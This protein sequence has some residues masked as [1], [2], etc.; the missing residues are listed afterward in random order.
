MRWKGDVGAPEHNPPPDRSRKRRR[1]WFA[2]ASVTLV[3]LLLFAGL[4]AGLRLFDYGYPATYFVRTESGDA[5]TGNR[6]F[7][8]R[9]FPRHFARTP[10]VFSFPSDKP[11]GTYRIFVMGGSAARGEPDEA[12]NF[13]RILGKMLSSHYPDARF[14]VINT[15]MVA[16]NSHVVHQIARECARLEPDLFIV[17][18]G[19]NEVIGPYG[20]GTVFR[21][22][23][24][25]LTTIR[26]GIRV[27][28]SRT[29]QLLDS[30]VQSVSGRQ[31]SVS[32]WRGMEMFLENRVRFDDPRLKSGYAHFERNL[33]DIIRAARE[34]GAGIILSTVATNLKDNAPFAAVHRRGLSPVREADWEEHY[35]AG[36]VLEARYYSAEAVER[37]QRALRIDDQYA[38]LH[39]RLASCYEQLGRYG[40]AHAHYVRARDMDALRFR[41]DTQIN[42]IIRK[43]ASGR[44]EEGV[45]LVDAERWL[46][47]SDRT[48]HGIPGDELFY[49]HVHMNF[50]GNYV[51]AKAVFTR[52][53]SVLPGH[54]RSSMPE[55]TRILSPDQCAVLLAYTKWD[56]YRTLR[57]IANIMAH[58]PFTNQLDYRE[59]RKQIA[60]SLRGLEAYPTP[61]ALDLAIGAYRKAL[62]SDPDDWTLHAHFAEL[63]AERGNVAEAIAEWRRALKC[64]PGSPEAYNDLGNLLAQQGALDE[65][66]DCFVEALRIDPYVVEAHNNLGLALKKTGK[67]REAVKHFS[68][69][70]RLSPGNETIRRNLESCVQAG[71]QTEEEDFG[72]D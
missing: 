12:F 43:T 7:G 3:P 8:W 36:I 69:A 26:A 42:G 52:L 10:A 1:R 9:F 60:E 39:F 51:L 71:H 38:D 21:A 34:S 53:R 28:S 46:E 31:R 41:A 37:Y 24:P 72:P 68:R 13:A 15:A 58:P 54:I 20:P 45:Y 67:T 2:A 4:E 35:Q 30:L 32:E 50:Y 70:L 23:S 25:N 64:A 62:A 65:A 18:L 19:N 49:E 56:L 22:F 47:D 66:A 16:I 17:Y 11:P 48:P 5:Y 63:H 14:E 40:E 33:A 29:G 44:E 61:A 59:R 57:H 55:G 6:R 27:K